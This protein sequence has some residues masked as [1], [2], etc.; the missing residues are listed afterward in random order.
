MQLQLDRFTTP[1]G[2]LLLVFDDAGLRALDFVDFEERMRR[3]LRLHYGDV[4]LTDAPAPAAITAPL[5]AYF[6]GDLAA[7]DSVK[8]ATG[9]TDFQ[10]EVWAA[11]RNIPAGATASYGELAAAVGR[12]KASRAIGMANGS[13]P[14]GIVV[15]CHRVI[16][17][18]GTLTGYAGGVERKRWL[19]RHEGALADALI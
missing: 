10:R 13:N 14:I 1:I 15:P 8:V 19:L 18:N 6:A 11:L 4:T 5:T 9:G 3:L 12:P 16:G 7:L 17:A 2:E